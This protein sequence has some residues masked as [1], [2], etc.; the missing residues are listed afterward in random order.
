MGSTGAG[1]I[2]GGCSVSGGDGHSSHFDLCS[3]DVDF[4][5]EHGL[6]GVSHMRMPFA[7]AC[8]SGAS[9]ATSLPPNKHAVATRYQVE[10]TE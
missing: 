6:S 1:E 2:L 7:A 3:F 8:G 9:S 5:G 10:S 4:D